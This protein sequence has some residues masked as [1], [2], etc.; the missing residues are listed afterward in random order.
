MKSARKPFTVLQLAFADMQDSKLALKAKKNGI[1]VDR[2]WRECEAMAGRIKS[3]SLGLIE[4][5]SSTEEELSYRSV[6][7]LHKSVSDFL[8]TPEAQSRIFQ[9]LGPQGFV[10]EVYLMR[11][12]LLDLK[13]VQQRLCEDHRL[14]RLDRNDWFDHVKPI[15]DDFMH[16]ARMAE[17]KTNAAHTSLV[18]EFDRV[19]TSLWESVSFRSGVEKRGD[20]HWYVTTRNPG[21][22]LEIR[23]G[24][25][26]RESKTDRIDSLVANEDLDAPR[27]SVSSP[28]GSLIYKMPPSCGFE[29]LVR[30]RGLQLYVQAKYGSLPVQPNPEILPNPHKTTRLTLNLSKTNHNQPWNQSASSIVPNPNTREAESIYLPRERTGTSSV[31]R[32]ARPRTTCHK[33]PALLRPSAFAME[34]VTATSD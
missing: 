4:V 32:K 31:Q 27:A 16:Y 7:F 18:D 23:D 28:R 8:E 9:C 24:M 11:S 30:S 2:Q 34:A 13:T 5:S 29:A 20:K 26:D 6:Q 22:G 12:A 1:P 17:E 14:V 10:P 25:Y 21:P 33:T 15:V 19:T 3:R